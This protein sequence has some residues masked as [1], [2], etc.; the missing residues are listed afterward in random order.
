[1]EFHIHTNVSNLATG[2]ML[3][4]NPTKKCDQPIT[5]ASKLLNNVEKNYTTIER[6]TLAMV[7]VLHK[8]KHYLLKNK[9]VFYMALLYLVKKPQLSRQITR[10]LLLFL[11]YNFSLVYKPRCFHLVVDVVLWLLDV[12]EN[13]GVF[14]KTID[15]S[16]FI[17]Q[18]E[19]L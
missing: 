7:Y 10:W 16:L 1:M 5:Y 11:E 9:F 14:N 19:W 13:L 17:L 18:L 6:E 15:A 8:F 4:Q 3:A 12:I 2:A